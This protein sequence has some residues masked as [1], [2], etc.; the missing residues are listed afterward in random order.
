MF[1]RI[2]EMRKK[3]YIAAL[4]IL[5]GGLAFC[6]D[7]YVGGNSYY[8][9]RSA[10]NSFQY[11]P[12]RTNIVY[13]SYNKINIDATTYNAAASELK[14]KI[15]KNPDSGV[16]YINLANL[17]VKA[18]DFQK[19]VE[20]LVKLQDDNPSAIDSYTKKEAANLLGDLKAEPKNDS[21]RTFYY[22]VMSMAALVSGDT[23][24]AE[25]L[26]MKV[27]SGAYSPLLLRPV[28]LSV[29]SKTQNNMFAISCC[30]KFLQKNP[31][32]VEMR[33]LK[34][35]FF[36]RS[37]DLKSAAGEY[38]RI[39]ALNPSD[40]EALYTLYKQVASN[41]DSDK[42]LLSKIYKIDKP[43]KRDY[44]RMYSDLSDVMLKH[45]DI[46]NAYK[47][48]K[49]LTEKFPD[50]ADG[51]IVL[52]EVYRREGK[53]EEAYKVLEKVKD[54]AE[55]NEQISKY[56]VALAKMSDKP[57]TEAESLMNAGLYKQAL[58]VLESAEQTNLYVLISSA[59][60]AYFSDYKQKSLDFLNK[61]MVLYPENADVYSAFAYVYLCEK[62]IES[63]KNYI[64][65][66][67]KK[68][69]GNETALRVRDAVLKAEA[70][71]YVK[72]AA[73]AADSQDYVKVGE[74][75]D[76]ALAIDPKNAMMYYYK[77][78]ALISQNNYSGA[79][80]N[81]KKSTEYDKNYAPAYYSLG[82]AYDYLSDKQNALKNYLKYT[83]MLPSGT[84][85]DS[86]KKEYAYTRIK[87]IRGY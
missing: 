62:D 38:S 15:S 8:N 66:A 6:A 30:E 47:Y 40:K 54:K 35:G 78:L 19:A 20:T 71:S 44:Q 25:N 21:D 11:T 17:Y 2:Y 9:S 55:N 26:I 82:M 46:Q 52:S 79:V 5:S 80:T 36:E 70:D 29:L 76:K 77:S 87:K 84:V 74:I 37:G 51:Y 75:A 7:A 63:A 22:T 4:I 14:R 58:E 31:N 45:D 69:P 34:A 53:L 23:V 48:A 49:V 42:V 65:K 61:A 56:N 86:E 10:V 13:S 73:A 57:L 59:K 1:V 27:M 50:N 41:G 16:N 83:E 68:S 64:N 12:G 60:A 85:E 81:L 18:G 32:D 24:Q 39:I 43:E 72:Y 67:L 28:L 33:K 3:L